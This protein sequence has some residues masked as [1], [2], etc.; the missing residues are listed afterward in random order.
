MQ[1]CIICE[2]P[3]P[4]KYLRKGVK[5]L[6]CSRSCS[7]KHR[8][9]K[10]IICKTCKKPFRA[11]GLRQNQE[12]CSLACI[13]REPCQEC[14]I[15]ITGRAK[16]QGGIKKFCTRNCA[17]KFRSA[18]GKFNYVAKGFAESIKKHGL[19]KCDLCGQEN[20]NFLI[21]HHKD[22]NR[23]NNKFNNL[24]TLCANCHHD[25]HFT[26]SHN[27]QKNIE[28]AMYIAKKNFE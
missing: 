1:N 16:F 18:E 10:E 14:G 22:N 26:N 9:E 20:I 24:Q 3:F 7:Y 21:V 25:I 13:Q 11:H 17:A 28:S 27:R 5:Q 15:I 12:Y 6:C 19:I 2:T 23:K 8:G 4:L